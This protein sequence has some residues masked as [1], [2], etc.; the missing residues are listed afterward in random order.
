M[1]QAL[2]EFRAPVGHEALRL[3]MVAM[4]GR[5]DPLLDAARFAR[6]LRQANDAEVADVRKVGDDEYEISSQR[7]PIRPV[8]QPAS[9]REEAPPPAG[10]E[11]GLVEA[12]TTSEAAPA[13]RENGQRFGVRFR[14]GSR[15]PLRPGEIPLIGVVQIEPPAPSEPIPAEQPLEPV[16]EE[17][18]PR[19]RRSPRKRTATAAT[20][21][22]A[23]DVPEGGRPP[24]PKRPRPRSR[25]KPE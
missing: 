10:L 14:R 7:G 3:R 23:P 15:G 24:A 4:H 9:T 13:T 20:P 2:S 5:E 17:K 12:V 8:A 25:K 21:P 11:D 6:L 1:S 19:P 22:D 16:Q 18:R